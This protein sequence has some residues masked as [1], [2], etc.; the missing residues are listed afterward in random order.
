[1]ATVKFPIA[2]IESLMYSVDPRMS[3]ATHLIDGRNFTW[4]SKGPK[5][6]FGATM[7]TPFTMEQ[8]RDVQAV[9]I[10]GQALTFTQD[11]ILMWR[12]QV[13]YMWE[14]LY[15]FAAPTPANTR[16]P[17]QTAFLNGEILV[18][19]PDRGLFSAPLFSSTTN[20]WFR[21]LTS[22]DIPGLPSRIKGMI[23]VRGRAIL[24]DDERVYWSDVGDFSDLTPSAAGA[25]F[26]RI[27]GI[28]AGTYV[29]M[30]SWQ[31]GF[32]VWTTQGAMIAEFIDDDATWF[33]QPL[34]SKERPLNPW[35][36]LE[37][38]TGMSAML[39]NHG[40]F[41]SPDQPQG[42]TPQ[43]NE[44]FRDYIRHEPQKSYFFRL[45]YDIED[46][47]VYIL[48]S[49][50][51]ATFQRAFVLRPTVDKWGLFN[52]ETHG[53]G[54]WTQEDFGYV[55]HDGTVFKFDDSFFRECDPEE[56]RGL[57]R[58]YPRLQKSMEIPSST[59]SSR[60][61]TY[62]PE[63]LDL[64]TEPSRPAWYESE[65]FTP[66]APERGTMDSWI[67]VGYLLSN[68]LN[69]SADAYAEFQEIVINTPNL[70]PPAGLTFETDYRADYFYPESEDWNYGGTIIP[71]DIEVDWMTDS[72]EEDW[73]GGANRHEDW[74]AMF[75]YGLSVDPD[76]E[77]ED[78]NIDSGDEDFGGN[79]GDYP[80]LDYG[81]SIHA[82]Q[83]GIT[84][85]DYPP[86]L[87][88]F[89][90]GSQTYAVM[91]SGSLHHMRITALDIGDWYHLR[92]AALTMNYGGQQG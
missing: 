26:Q 46:E 9:R 39:T 72:G 51:G 91:T 45:E 27:D 6:G 33:F 60:A 52:E 73:N 92:S 37:L 20:L 1:M 54:Q 40:L 30:S 84:V 80:Q 31:N 23:V 22:I 90:T 18:A 55:R 11:A 34:M 62:D 68:E 14:L 16:F 17:W 56:V 85:V 10:R 8:P 83:D 35:C 53:M 25:G 61:L 65:T 59:M 75:E 13:P 86:V 12:N 2:N 69:M 89:A 49:N 66:A 79:S 38:S 32:I 76:T 5:S 21:P 81:L 63:L 77:Y 3:T 48:E 64:I 24:A 74:H 41:Y 57:D 71:S 19:H 44:F 29:A 4:D 88:R 82:S 70:Q 78:W 87:A 7:L 67:H 50:N 36:I 42:W 47:T 28:V 43:F 15:Q 58:Q